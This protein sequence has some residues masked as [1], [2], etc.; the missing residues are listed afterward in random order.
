MK[1]RITSPA[2]TSSTSDSAISAAMS[3]LSVLCRAAPAVVRPA[4]SDRS[5]RKSVLDA[6]GAGTLPKR[7]PVASA[8]TNANAN[9]EASS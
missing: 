1:L 9:T 6:R 8:T 7:S 4:A 2:P 5:S 3:A